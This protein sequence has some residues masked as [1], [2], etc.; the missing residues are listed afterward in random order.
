MRKHD[1][2]AT[3]FWRRASGSLPPSVRRRYLAQLKSAESF[4]VALDRALNAWKSLAEVLHLP[5]HHPAH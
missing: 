4:D 1:E 2:F 5:P 3:A